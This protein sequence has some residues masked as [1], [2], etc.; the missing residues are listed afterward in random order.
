VPGRCR[1]R[2]FEMMDVGRP[3]MTKITIDLGRRQGSGVLS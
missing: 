2:Q 1:C 3:P